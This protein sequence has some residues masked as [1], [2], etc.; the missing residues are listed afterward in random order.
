MSD[1]HYPNRK[2]EEHYWATRKAPRVDSGTPYQVTQD[3][4]DELRYAHEREYRQKHD[5]HSQSMNIS[6]ATSHLENTLAC[7]LSEDEKVV[8][9]RIKTAFDNPAWTVDLITKAFNDIDLVC[10]D[11]RLKG[12]TRIAWN[13]SVKGLTKTMGRNYPGTLGITDVNSWRSVLVPEITLNAY[14]LFMLPT[15]YSK[16]R[17]VWSTLM[18]E[19]ITRRRISTSRAQI[20]DS[21]S[22]LNSTLVQLQS[23]AEAYGKHTSGPFTGQHKLQPLG[24][25]YGTR[26]TFEQNAQQMANVKM[27]WELAKN[28]S[29]FLGT[30]WWEPWYCFDDWNGGDTALCHRL[31][32]AD[33]YAAGEAPTDTLKAWRKAAY[34][35]W[36][37][38]TND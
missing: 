19:M 36:K 17:E 37:S 8:A 30:L 32:A 33:G 31:Y 10:F 35:P 7:A 11:R 2:D 16:R 6:E 13:G 38:L 1:W 28:F 3:E 27:L 20:E 22:T 15:R 23:Y 18:H 12:R 29:S 14:T 24:V 21:F 4:L 34:S 9:A 26:Y 5:R 25:E